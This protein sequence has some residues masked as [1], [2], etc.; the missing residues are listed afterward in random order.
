MNVAVIPEFPVIVIDDTFSEYDYERMMRE[1]EFISVPE[2][3]LLLMP[4]D[5]GAAVDDDGEV[6]KNNQA[7]FLNHIYTDPE[8]SD[9]Q[10]LG[11]TL[12]TN[13][14]IK[15]AWHSIHGTWGRWYDMITSSSTLVSYYAEK[16]HY[17]AHADSSMFTLLTYFWKEPKGFEGGDLILWEDQE[18][19]RGAHIT[20]EKNMT[21]IFPSAMLHT[22]EPVSLTNDEFGYGR[23]VVTQFTSVS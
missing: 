12:I 4:E 20:I 16:G 7:I 2:K 17:K 8:V 5:T 18:G 9:I 19:D 3:K 15:D 21:V 14:E 6:R 11:S 22:V 23:Y 13:Q 1:L 10:T